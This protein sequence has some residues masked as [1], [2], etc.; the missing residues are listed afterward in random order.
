MAD[1]FICATCSERKASHITRDFPTQI[2]LAK[3]RVTKT[4]HAICFQCATAIGAALDLDIGSLQW[5]RKEV[6]E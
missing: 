3:S 5:P 6:P 2:V 1:T 4:L